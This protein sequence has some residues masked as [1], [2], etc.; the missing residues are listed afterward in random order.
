MQSTL[1][2][3]P[4]ASAHTHTHKRCAGSDAQK[5][6]QHPLLGGERVL[7]AIQAVGAEAVDTYQMSTQ[8][9]KERGCSVL[10]S[11]LRDSLTALN[12]ISC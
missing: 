3:D 10:R 9:R 1:V 4:R 2:V 8:E 12:L 7:L 6:G 5:S 11:T